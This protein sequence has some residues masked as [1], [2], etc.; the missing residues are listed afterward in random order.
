MKQNDK[1]TNNDLQNTTHKTEDRVTCRHHHLI[2]RYDR[3]TCRHHHL[4]NR[5]GIYLSQMTTDMFHLS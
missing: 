5:Y 4:I 3:V 2:N 1:M